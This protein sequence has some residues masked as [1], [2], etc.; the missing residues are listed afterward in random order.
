[1]VPVIAVH[2]DLGHGDLE[3]GE[4]AQNQSAPRSCVIAAKSA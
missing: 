2:G 3:Q 1:M 4:E